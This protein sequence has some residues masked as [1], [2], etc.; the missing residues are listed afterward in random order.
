MDYVT[1]IITVAIVT[2]FDAFVAVAN[3]TDVDYSYASDDVTTVLYLLLPLPMKN[4]LLFP[5]FLVPL[6]SPL[7][8]LTLM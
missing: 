6:L 3:F 8:I 2:Y 7:L 5:L 1:D 4:S